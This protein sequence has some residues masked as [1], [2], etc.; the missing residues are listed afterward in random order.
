LGV[1]TA[2][3]AISALVGALRSGQSFFGRSIWYSYVYYAAESLA[4]MIPALGAVLLSAR[5]WKISM[6]FHDAP[7][8]DEG[9]GGGASQQQHLLGGT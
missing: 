7:F 4:I 2:A 1:L 9:T 8:G 3:A 6:H 5:A